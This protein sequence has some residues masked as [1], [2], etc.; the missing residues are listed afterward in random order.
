MK[1]NLLGNTGLKVSEFCLGTMT[2]GGIG[3]YEAIGN[4]NQSESETILSQAV[5]AGINFI[6]SANSYSAG[7]AEEI[8]G[9]AI[10]NLGLNRDSLVIATK[11]RDRM[12]EAPNDLGLSRKHILL[13]VE[14]SL[15]R[16]KTDYIDLYQIHGYDILTPIEETLRV[17]DDLVQSGKVR[18]IGTSN[19]AAWHLMKALDHSFYH[20]L[21]RIQSL[22]AYYSLASRELEREHIPLLE[23]QKIGLMVYSPLAAGFLSGKYTRDNKGSTGGRRDKSGFPPI[24][25]EKAHRVLAVLQPM[26]T[27]R[28][29]SVAQLSLAWLLQQPAVTSVILGVKTPEQL[30][31]NLKANQVSLSAE[32]LKQ[33]DEVSKLPYE[34][35]AF[36]LD[37]LNTDRKR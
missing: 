27:A 32:E 34:Y 12:S 21:S 17:L 33:L 15:K 30:Q 11:V 23:D 8:L 4:L 13:Q 3:V 18:Y 1:Y 26:A 14:A 10:H 5:E 29:I 16:L 20:N 31:E 2:F 22:Q 36:A 25:E 9:Q 7:K 6:D 19:V 28:G 24:D 35:P 37:Y